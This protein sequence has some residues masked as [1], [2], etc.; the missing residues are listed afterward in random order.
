MGADFSMRDIQAFIAASPQQSPLGSFSELSGAV[1]T[2]IH[3]VG[4]FLTDLI[5]FLAGGPIGAALVDYWQQH[6]K[7]I[8]LGWVDT[9][10]RGSGSGRLYNNV[11]LSTDGFYTLDVTL[12]GLG[13]SGGA[14]KGSEFDVQGGAS[15]AG[16]PLRVEVEPGTAAHD[17][18]ASA[19]PMRGG[20]G[21]LPNTAGLNLRF[22]GE[23]MI[24]CHPP[25]LPPPF[26]EIHAATVEIIPDPVSVA[27]D[28]GAVVPAP[29]WHLAAASWRTGNPNDLLF[30]FRSYDLDTVLFYD[31]KTTHHY[32]SLHAGSM[33]RLPNLAASHRLV[34]RAPALPTSARAMIPAGALPWTAGTSAVVA[35]P[36]ASSRTQAP[37]NPLR[38]VDPEGHGHDPVEEDF[39]LRTG[40]YPVWSEMT[41][42]NRP[43]SD[44]CGGMITVTP[45]REGGFFL[46]SLEGGGGSPEFP[47]MTNQPCL[48][49]LRRWP[50]TLVGT[51]AR[52][53]YNPRYPVAHSAF[54]APTNTGRLFVPK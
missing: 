18:C 14:A 15:A 36:G 10:W 25:P 35:F 22:E 45:R 50:A 21:T 43:P 30:C 6:A 4:R 42:S 44:G 23:I 2:P 26:I 53:T 33:T 1:T 27:P 41:G 31:F 48:I 28:F 32:G 11:A 8:P 39:F 38:A 9:G 13:A 19:F 12:N 24:D 16:R 17:F 51:W 47:M 20:F 3:K 49:Y 52:S 40:V 7:E 37:H 34:A 54:H 5:G 46:C 29:D